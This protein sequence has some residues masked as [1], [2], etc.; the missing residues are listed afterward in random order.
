MA[1]CLTLL[2]EACRSPAFGRRHSML[3]ESQILPQRRAMRKTRPNPGLKYWFFSLGFHS[4]SSNSSPKR[5]W[6]WVTPF[7][8]PAIMTDPQS[9]REGD[10]ELMT[11]EQR[12][13]AWKSHVLILWGQWDLPYM[14]TRS[15]SKQ[16]ILLWGRRGGLVNY[17]DFTG[18]KIEL[19]HNSLYLLHKGPVRFFCATRDRNG[20]SVGVKSCPPQAR[21]TCVTS[22]TYLMLFPGPPCVSKRLMH[23][24][25]NDFFPL[26]LKVPEGK[27][28]LNRPKINIVSLLG[29]PI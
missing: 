13:H 29:L 15:I 9:R 4:F 3:T 17:Q 5:I 11:K 6:N 21:T 23:L 19:P 28:N 26:L 1:F 27:R 12:K 7:A 20:C 8:H 16:R 2:H 18:R 24:W 14:M 22:I 10:P 25:V